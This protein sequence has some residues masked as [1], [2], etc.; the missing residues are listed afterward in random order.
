[1]ILPIRHADGTTRKT[2]VIIY[3]PGDA[4]Y[5]RQSHRANTAASPYHRPEHHKR[6]SNGRLQR[7]PPRQDGGD[8]G[9]P[10]KVV[11]LAKMLS[12]CDC[13]GDDGFYHDFLEDVTQE[14][15][16][17]GDLVKVVIPRP[18]PSISDQAASVV[19]GVGKVFLEFVHLDSATRCKRRLNGMLWY[20]GK[21]IA[22][23][24]FPHAKF[25]AGDYK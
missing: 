17:F 7:S 20:S 2:L 25:A 8:E 24:F 16:K 23:Q 12:P 14:A 5:L 10:T 4:A 13:L 19:A 18:S 21:E 11:C 9:E 1:M 15:R 6:W 22:A 3:K